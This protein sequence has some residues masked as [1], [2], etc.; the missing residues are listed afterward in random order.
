MPFSFASAFWFEQY[1]RYIKPNSAKNYAGAL[2]VLRLF[3]GEILLRD[4]TIADIRRYQDERRKKAGARLLNGEMSVLQ[5]ILKEARLWKA[6]EDDYRPLPIS[7]RGAGHSLNKEDEERLRAV[8]FS[9]PKWLFRALHDNHAL[10]N[11]GLRGT[12]PTEAS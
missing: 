6:I 9:R 12:A 2:K 3:F 10:D 8:A 5:M 11:H 1:S 4:I 7:R